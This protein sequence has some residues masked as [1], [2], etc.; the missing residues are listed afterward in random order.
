[1]N[2]RGN[3]FLIIILSAAI[4]GNA[5][6]STAVHQ[7]IVGEKGAMYGMAPGDTVWLRR[8]ESSKQE[9]VR[10][11]SIDE[12]GIQ[13]K[14]E[15]G[16]SVAA[17]W[18]DLYAVGPKPAYAEP[19]L[20]RS[21]ASKAAEAVAYVIGGAALGAFIAAACVGGTMAGNPGCLEMIADR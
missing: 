3:Q 21:R 4:L 5:A 13:G 10:I 7:P 6:C 2:K 15:H 1:M 19:R 17:E 18:D 16:R 14:D 20:A 8:A 11:R 12:D 9:R